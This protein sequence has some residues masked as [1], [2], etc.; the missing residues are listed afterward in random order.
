MTSDKRKYSII[1]WIW[2]LK[3]TICHYKSLNTNIFCF[4]FDCTK[5]FDRISFHTLF[6]KLLT[7]SLSGVILGVLLFSYL[8][9]QSR[10]KWKTNFV[11]LLEHQMEY[12]KLQFNFSATTRGM[13]WSS[14]KL[15]Q[16]C[17]YDI[18]CAQLKCSLAREYMPSR[19]TK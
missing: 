6:I 4:L 19:H 16:L 15:S 9:Q 8:H 5:A 11:Q 7:C 3:E 14:G 18:M 10:V 2:L 17:F 12:D 1:Q 13:F